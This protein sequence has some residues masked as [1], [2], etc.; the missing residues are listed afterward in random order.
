MK[1]K[2]YE[3]QIGSKISPKESGY[4]VLRKKRYSTEDSEICMEFD[5]S[6]ES[7]F[8]EINYRINDLFSIQKEPCRD[9]SPNYNTVYFVNLTPFQLLRLKWMFGRH[10]F[11]QQKFW[12]WLVNIT[13]AILAVVMSWMSWNQWNKIDKME[14]KLEM[15]EQHIQNKEKEI[16]KLNDIIRAQ[17]LKNKNDTI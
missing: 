14:L 3:V 5:Y 13:I 2:H 12:M 16:L 8:E 9:G 11:Q 17:E 1:I 6:R 10:L 4:L 15:K 7:R